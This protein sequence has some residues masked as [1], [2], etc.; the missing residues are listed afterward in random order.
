MRRGGCRLSVLFVA[1]SV[2]CSSE[3][4]GLDAVQPRFVTDW[5]A[6]PPPST[7]VRLGRAPGLDAFESALDAGQRPDPSS[8]DVH[9]RLSTAGLFLPPAC[10]SDPACL[11]VQVGRVRLPDATLAGLQVGATF[12]TPAGPP[13]PLDVIVV[14]DVSASLR[15]DP[16]MEAIRLGL[17]ALADGLDEDDRLALITFRGNVEL[18]VPLGRVE[19]VRSDF[20]READLMTFGGGTDLASGVSMGYTIAARERDLER[21]SRLIVLTDGVPTWGFTSP[22]QLID[23]VSDGIQSG[24]LLSGFVVG[25]ESSDDYFE[26]L[27]ERAAGRLVVLPE[28]S[29]L[30]EALRFEV[31]RD[32]R[33]LFSSFRIRVE[34]QTEI[35]S[36]LV[37]GTTALERIRGAHV[38][39]IPQILHDPQLGTVA[40]GFDAEG[41]DSLLWALLEVGPETEYLA[42]VELSYRVP[43]GAEYRQE[44]EVVV[45]SS[46][47][48]D[49]A[50][51]Y[52]SAPEVAQN[53]LRWSVASS[54][55][56]A[57][58]AAGNGR[59]QEAE[60]ELASAAAR[61]E[62]FLAPRGDAAPLAREERD[63]VE[64]LQAVFG[65]GEPPEDAEWP[66]D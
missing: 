10:C 46:I 2:A 26:E 36:V 51:P 54:V 57:L 29:G 4:G 66:G 43:G 60:T 30:E 3:T 15:T 1:L 63:L 21:Q 8:F 62:D 19:D 24:T 9:R 49:V 5:C 35:S 11:Q 45:P 39:E 47:W 52:Y 18:P 33:T 41:G 42:R 23:V 50:P 34:L 31:E 38:V 55:E 13:P 12:E 53:Y 28:P 58:R 64:R 40:P 56:R 25:D 61:V 16:V 44:A 27:I 17:R 20:V 65:H 32:T 48:S 59:A 7:A 6:E 37:S 22:E 14:V